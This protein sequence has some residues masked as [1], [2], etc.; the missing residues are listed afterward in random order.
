MHTQSHP[1]THS[2]THNSLSHSYTH[3]I[4]DPVFRFACSSRHTMCLDCFGNMCKQMLG[5]EK[6]RHFDQM[7]FN[8]PCPGPGRQSSSVYSTVALTP[9]HHTHTHT[10]THTQVMTASTLQYLTLTILELW[11]KTKHLYVTLTNRYC[12]SLT[13]YLSFLAVRQVY[14][15]VRQLVHSCRG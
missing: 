14:Q 10:H 4:R 12:S 1:P 11:M 3:I 2:H 5:A 7:G 13:V 8:I 6:F 9:S 15:D